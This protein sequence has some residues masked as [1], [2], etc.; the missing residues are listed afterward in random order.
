MEERVPTGIPGLDELMSGGLPRGRSI[1][2]TGGCGTGK[3]TLALQYL[4]NGIIKYGEPGLLITLEQNHEEIRKDMLNFGFDLK[5][6]ED[7]GKLI[8]IDTSLSRV[9]IRDFIT[10]PPTSSTPAASFSLLPG[11]FNMDNIIALA[12]Q[13]AEQIGAKRIVIDSLP[14]LDYLIT[15]SHDL[16]RTLITMNYELKSK[17]LTTLIITEGQDEDGLSMHGVEEYI[18]DGVIVLKVNEALDT[19]TIKIRKM[20]TIKHTLKP[21]TFELTPTGINVKSAKTL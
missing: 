14:A 7:E 12:I 9:G 18:A 20:R 10:A 17:G 19:R 1:L 4:V 13:S 16:R 21:T 11:E 2:L 6:H 8:I 15:E 3:S 5:K